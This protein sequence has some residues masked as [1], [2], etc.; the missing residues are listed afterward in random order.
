M[1]LLKVTLLLVMC[2]L[3]PV[4]PVNTLAQCTKGDCINGRGTFAYSDGVKYAGRGKSRVSLTQLEKAV[5][6]ETNLLRR[7]PAKYVK[8]M[9]RYKGAGEAIGVLRSTKPLST[10]KV[11][12]GLC[13]AAKDHMN[14]KGPK[15]DTG[16][17]GS[18]GSDCQTRTNRYGKVARK[19]AENINYGRDSAEEI[20]VSWLIDARTPSRG[21]RKNI[22]HPSYRHIGVGCG[23]H[24]KW[25]VMCVQN[26]AA[27]YRERKSSVPKS[28]VPKKKPSVRKPYV[29]KFS[30]P[31]KKPSVRSP[32]RPKSLVPKQ[33]PS[34]PSRG[35][36]K[37]CNTNC[38]NGRCI[39][40]C[41][42]NGKC[43]TRTYK[44]K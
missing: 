1:K 2:C 13:R 31:K 5:I 44:S 21:H 17:T 11:S 22:L 23:Y 27:D 8:K 26:L 34:R 18:D 30:V 43:T 37:K 9:R 12:P 33:K 28:S 20:V 15:G 7:N 24:T 25:K 39:T 6:N 40:T 3:L 38:I 32:Y 42:V 10:L 29:P 16:H 14:D 35:Y 19:W 36:A 41:C 4:N